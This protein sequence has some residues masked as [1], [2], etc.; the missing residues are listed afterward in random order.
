MHSNLS[1][2]Q[3][4]GAGTDKRCACDAAG[5]AAHK[6]SDDACVRL[7]IAESESGEALSPY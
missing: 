4:R 3:G 7:V 5:I 2:K 6:E 1:P